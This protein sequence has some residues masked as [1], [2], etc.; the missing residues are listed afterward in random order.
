MNYLPLTK[1]FVWAMSMPSS[2]I[3]SQV[4]WPESDLCARVPSRS[5]VEKIQKHFNACA[6]TLFKTDQS[7]LLVS[8]HSEPIKSGLVLALLAWPHCTDVPVCCL[9][10]AIISRGHCSGF[11]L[12]SEMLTAK[13]SMVKAS[14]IFKSLVWLVS[15]LFRYSTRSFLQILLW[16]WLK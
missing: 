7:V 13:R 12:I 9:Q 2:F 5:P 14:K 11:F 10:S 3:N 1:T 8:P 15:Y 16:G 6:A 4:Y